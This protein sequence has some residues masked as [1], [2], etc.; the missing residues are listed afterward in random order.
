VAEQQ[1]LPWAQRALPEGMT[2]DH[3]GRLEAALRRR[4]RAAKSV[5]INRRT[6][7]IKL[8]T[9]APPDEV[10][11]EVAALVGRSARKARLLE[12]SRDLVVAQARQMRQ[13]PLH[14]LSPEE[15]RWLALAVLVM[16]EDFEDDG[17]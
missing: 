16:A 15:R 10:D 1:D 5:T 12:Q 7:V 6:G 14:L 4:G 2:A 9:D 11:A 13:R 3:A 17:A 8:Q